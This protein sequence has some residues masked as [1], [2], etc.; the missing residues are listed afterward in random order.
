MK[1]DV[2]CECHRRDF[3]LKMEKHSQRI[4]KQE[5]K[6]EEKNK[7]K[8][9][10]KTTTTTVWKVK[11]CFTNLAGFV[12]FALFMKEPTSEIRKHL[13][14]LQDSSFWYINL[15]MMVSECSFCFF[16]LGSF[17]FFASQFVFLAHNW[18]YCFVM[19]QLALNDLIIVF[20]SFNSIIFSSFFY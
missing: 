14:C 20:I 6:D 19:W 10:V 4:R 18:D 2:P 5:I 12:C 3:R 17:F 7:E 15:F 1:Q 13:N 11:K 16:S 8:S 9:M